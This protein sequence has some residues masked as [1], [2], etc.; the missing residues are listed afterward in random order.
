M[1]MKR[2]M[3]IECPGCGSNR[4]VLV[5]KSINAQLNPEAK[6]DL[7]N[8]KVNLFCC[9]NC[10]VQAPIAIDLLYHDMEKE[11][12]V[13]F[14]PFNKMDN[15]DFLEN[16]TDKGELDL[17]RTGAEDPP[18]YFRNVHIVFSMD[19]L[20]RYVIFRGRLAERK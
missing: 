3:E 1:S 17:R 19:E 6:E 2:I 16:F 10:S 20:V 13:Q 14:F 9:G 11:F 12:C 5:W 18:D 15:N 4:E 8:G 7:L